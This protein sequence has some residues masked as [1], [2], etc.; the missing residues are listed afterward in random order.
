MY[1]SS[2]GHNNPDGSKFCEKCGASLSI[3]GHTKAKMASSS[4][5]RKLA[6]IGGALVIICFFLPWVMA[7]CSSG[8]LFGEDVEIK[9]SGLELATGRI[10]DLDTLYNMGSY[11]GYDSNELTDETSTP[12]FFLI[13]LLGLGAFYS[14]TDKK[15]GSI[16]AM[17]CGI[18]GII[19]LIVFG[20]KFHNAKEE[21]E[22]S[23]YSM[24]SMKLQFGYFLAWIGFILQTILGFLGL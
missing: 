10:H 3:S 23:S 11:S 6:S 19:F 20:V 24:L 1:C 8:G 5:L 12:L 4:P 9:A 22:L 21:L 2:C 14:L 15:S 16:V 13:P 18:L 17:I 7:S